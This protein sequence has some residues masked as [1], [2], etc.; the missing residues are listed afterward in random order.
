MDINNI[1]NEVIESALKMLVSE[2]RAA[3]AEAIR[4]KTAAGPKDWPKV[5]QSMLAL[6]E[7]LNDVHTEH[8]KILMMTIALLV[9]RHPDERF[10]KKDIER[11]D[12]TMKLN[13]DTSAITGLLRAHLKLYASGERMHTA[14]IHMG[15]VKREADESDEQLTFAI[16]DKDG[17]HMKGASKDD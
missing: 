16:I 5:D 12:S 9:E 8:V 10:S 7:C 6:F 11:L 13:I 4:V 1:M 2:R 3:L 14:H 15:N 17:L